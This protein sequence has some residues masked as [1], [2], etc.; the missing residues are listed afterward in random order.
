M[1]ST[2][3]NPPLFQSSRRLPPFDLALLAVAAAAVFGVALALHSLQ[4]LG[5]AG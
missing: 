3:S 2:S 4:H 1:H 5:L